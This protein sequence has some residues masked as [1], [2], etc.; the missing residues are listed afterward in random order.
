[1]TLKVSASVAAALVLAGAVA[2]AAPNPEAARACRATLS[3]VGQQMY[4]VTAPHVT[5]SSNIADLM[6]THVRG[7]VM[8]G[9]LN[10]ADAQAAAPAVGECLRH[11]KG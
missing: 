5:A 4:D 7:L 9:Q 10:R 11:L 6:R 2:F 3:P 1:M 8:S